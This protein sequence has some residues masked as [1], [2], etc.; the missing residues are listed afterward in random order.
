MHVPGP[1][2]PLDNFILL[3]LKEKT[4]F[5]LCRS[6]RANIPSLNQRYILDARSTWAVA[7]QSHGM[8]IRSVNRTVLLL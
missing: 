6:L 5:I 1:R 2:N 7:V 4:M 8:F 3:K